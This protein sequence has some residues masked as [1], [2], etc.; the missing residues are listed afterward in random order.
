MD[1]EA[2]RTVMSWLERNKVDAQKVS[3]HNH[4]VS[5]AERM[6]ETAKHHFITGMAGT[7][8]NYPIREWDMWVGTVTE[9]IEHALTVYNQPQIFSGCIPG[10]STRL[11][12]CTFPPLGRR[13]LIF[14]GPQKR[15]SWGLHGVEGFI[16]GPTEK[17]YICYTGWVPTTGAKR[18]SD[19]VVLSPPRKY[20]YDLPAPPTQEEVVQ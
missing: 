1:N 4:R 17:N 18:I 9:N 13:M 19:T 2:S 3:L 14:E 10:W 11:Q 15:S 8:K 12:C 7:D 5:T 20:T 6:I 16:V